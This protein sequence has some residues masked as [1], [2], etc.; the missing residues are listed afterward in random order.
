MTKCTQCKKDMS[1]PETE[2]CVS[3]LIKIGDTEYEPNTSSFDCNKRC[4]DCNIVNEGGNVHHPGCDMEKCPKCKGQLI[5][6][7]CLDG[8]EDEE[9]SEE[10]EESELLI[11]IREFD[12]LCGK[13]P[14]IGFIGNSEFD[15]TK[16]KEKIVFFSEN[17]E[18]SLL[19]KVGEKKY[20][21]LRNIWKPNII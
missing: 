16:L 3:E 19:Q 6:C 21:I 12:V 5:S 20:I 14:N 17:S 8:N 18:E 13:Y 2:S 10:I 11:V 9:E 7:G 4:H 1:A 15:F